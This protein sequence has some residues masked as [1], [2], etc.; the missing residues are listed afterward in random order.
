[1]SLNSYLLIHNKVK[2]INNIINSTNCE[3]NII[4]TQY[5]TT[6]LITIILD[7]FDN[8]MD[9]DT[10]GFLWENNNFK[11]SF[12]MDNNDTYFNSIFET[13][14]SILC[15]YKRDTHFTIDFI[16]CSI[17]DEEHIEWI[18]MIENKYPVSIR[19]SLD[20]TGNNYESNWVLESHN[21]DIRPYYFN[22]NIDTYE[23]I[24]GSFADDGMVYVIDS[25]GYVFGAGRNILGE[26]G[27]NNYNSY[28]SFVQMNDISNAIK[29]SSGKYNCF[30]ITSD[31]KAYS[32][33]GNSNKVLGVGSTASKIP[34]L[35]QMLD[36]DGTSYLEDVKDI[37]CTWNGTFVLKTDGSLYSLGKN[38]GDSILGI[39]EN[40]AS[41]YT[42]LQQCRY[43][44]SY[45]TN[46]SKITCGGYHTLMIDTSGYVWACGYDNYS[47]ENCGKMG[48]GDFSNNYYFVPVIDSNDNHLK[49]IIQVEAKLRYSLFLKYDGTVY[50]A[51][52]LKLNYNASLDVFD[53]NTYNKATLIS[54]VSNA[55]MIAGSFQSFTILLKDGSVISRGRNT[56]GQLGDFTTSNKDYFVKVKYGDSST[57]ISN[58]C[59]VIGGG[60]QSYLYLNSNKYVGFGRNNHGQ[61][62]M[63]TS[64]AGPIH[65]GAITPISFDKKIR[66]MSNS[67]FYYM[68]NS[69]INTISEYNIDDEIYNLLIENNSDDISLTYLNDY[70]SDTDT[71]KRTNLRHSILDVIFKTNKHIRNIKT[72]NEDILLNDYTTGNYI[73]SFSSS[74]KISIDDY[75][76]DT[77]SLYF[78]LHNNNDFVEITF[79]SSLVR[80]TLE[81]DIYYVHDINNNGD[82][83]LEGSYN[84]YDETTLYNYK[85]IFGGLLITATSTNVSSSGDPHIY[86]Y[87][88]KPYELPN[89]VCNYRLIQGDDFIL[90]AST[91]KT[92]MFERN[93]IRDYFI[94]YIN[95]NKIYVSNSNIQKLIT[96]GVFYKCFYI[97]SENSRLFINL[98]KNIIIG[99]QYFTIQQIK[100]NPKTYKI[101]DICF[102][103]KLYGKCKITIK[104]YKN[105]Q[106]KY[107]IE[108]SS[109]HIKNMD[110]L[111]VREYNTMNYEIEKLYNIDY[112]HSLKYNTENSNKS[113]LLYL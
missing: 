56:Y 87:Y 50:Y 49:D 85:L 98:D 84:I 42:T 112:I 1:M 82:Y 39:G 89:K 105:P 103:H 62:G 20:E 109:K 99:N 78:N 79:D 12:F 3:Y 65:P 13:F 11:N 95:K 45:V 90:N 4:E 7:I 24:L 107:G 10:I 21:I 104:Y 18:N 77:D 110:G 27:V 68:N 91:R 59:M 92:T 72:T 94:E 60:I 67:D 32:C 37:A 88:G 43:E 73:Y 25:S 34:L 28:N 81:N 80:I 36:T 57:D 64:S 47:N 63:N 41:S 61:L 86:P 15:G 71:S 54:D 83:S 40:M 14:I 46:A 29:V 23:H 66:N 100:N 69:I 2:D 48:T 55:V 97:N 8:N 76:V 51:G 17:N 22:S 5:D 111:L 16:T 108:F 26:L 93:E 30:V 9:I 113:K 102:N 52:T 19:Y 96:D 33:G 6:S 58:V 70:I 53:G 101:Y 38:S 31:N 75:D 35:T 74:Q 106:E 44:N